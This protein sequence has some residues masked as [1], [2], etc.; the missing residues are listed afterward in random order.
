MSAQETL[1]VVEGYLGGHGTQWLAEDVEF[2]DPGQPQPHRGRSEVA[3]W[4]SGFYGGAFSDARAE[5]VSLVADGQR[6]GYEFVFTGVHTGSLFG[7]VPTGRAVRVPMAAFYDVEGGEI[8]RARLYYDAGC[9]RAELARP[10]RS[11]CVKPSS[12]SAPRK[13]R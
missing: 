11:E 13:P 9:L 12:G 10:E 4:L 6:A 5:P 1:Q 2:F 3:R 8:V 7:E